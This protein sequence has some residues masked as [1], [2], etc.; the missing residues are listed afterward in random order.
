MY[1]HKDFHFP[2]LV[3]ASCVFR[4][5]VMVALHAILT[6]PS[7]AHVAPSANGVPKSRLTPRSLPKSCRSLPWELA[8]G[9]VMCWAQMT[10]SGRAQQLP[11]PSRAA[12]SCQRLLDSMWHQSVPL[13]RLWLLWQSDS[14]GRCFTESPPPKLLKTIRT[15]SVQIVQKSTTILLA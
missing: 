5:A 2:G 10:S 4:G 15:P 8:E 14:F 9:C 1:L 13:T 6:F 12:R 7:L 11:V 3:P